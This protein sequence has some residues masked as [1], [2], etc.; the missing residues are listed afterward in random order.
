MLFMCL[1]VFR[2]ILVLERVMVCLLSWYIF[3][4]KVVWVCKEVFLKISVN[5][6]FE[7]GLIVCY[8]FV[9]MEC[10]VFMI[11][12][13]LVDV[14]LRLFRKLWFVSIGCGRVFGV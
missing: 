5:D 10:V 6:S 4:L 14:M 11:V 2:L 3:I 12:C 13:N 7:S 1:W 9:F 8:L